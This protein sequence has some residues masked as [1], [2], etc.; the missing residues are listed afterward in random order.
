MQNQWFKYLNSCGIQLFQLFVNTKD[1]AE[2]YNSNSEL[3]VSPAAGE[4]GSVCHH[5]EHLREA[6]DHEL[7]FNYLSA[8]ACSNNAEEPD[9]TP[10]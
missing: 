7:H 3:L 6:A 5:F 1:I 10:A 2:V 8:E 9:S 4:Q